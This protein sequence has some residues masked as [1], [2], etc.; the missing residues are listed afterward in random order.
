MRFVQRH[1]F[2]VGPDKFSL[3]QVCLAQ[4]STREQNFCSSALL[5]CSFIP[6]FAGEAATQA[7]QRKGM[8]VHITQVRTPQIQPPAH[9]LLVAARPG[10]T[11]VFV[12]CQQPLDIGTAQSHPFEGID[13]SF[14]IR[15]RRKTAD[16][17]FL[18]SHIDLGFGP[19]GLLLGLPFCTFQSGCG[20]DILWR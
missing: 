2:Q 15:G 20:E 19:P 6:L 3:L 14:G 18:T 12:C 17:L 9:L 13:A 1:F 16:Q 4:I 10:I 8:Q 5:F 11:C 7:R